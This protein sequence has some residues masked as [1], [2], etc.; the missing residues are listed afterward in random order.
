MFFCDQCGEAFTENHNLSRHKESKHAGV[1]YSC[2]KCSYQATRKD[3]LSRHMK[4]KH[5]RIDAEKEK[6][7]HDGD[8]MASDNLMIDAEK[9]KG[10]QCDDG[11]LTTT[12]V[13]GEQDVDHEAPRAMGAKFKCPHCSISLSSRGNLQKHI[14]LKHSNIRVLSACHY[15]PVFVT[16]ICLCSLLTHCLFNFCDSDLDQSASN[17]F[18]IISK[19]TNSA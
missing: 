16:K 1:K 9:E 7:G 14:N 5:R 17:P 2:D 18:G 10:G 19:A 12:D 8:I 13:G 15:C 3:N 6:G 11:D 4:T